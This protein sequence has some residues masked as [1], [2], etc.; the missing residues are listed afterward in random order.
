MGKNKIGFAHMQV[1][2]PCCGG[3]ATTE[4]RSRME[5]KATFGKMKVNLVEAS[6]RFYEMG[7]KLRLL[8]VH[9]RQ[10]QGDFVTEVDVERKG[11]KMS[12]V[13]RMGGREEKRE[14]PASQETFS[15][16]LFGFKRTVREGEVVRGH[17]FFEDLLQDFP[18]LTRVLSVGVERLGGVRLTLAD[19]QVEGL[20]MGLRMGGRVT[21][22][23]DL[24]T[25]TLG[26]V[27]LRLEG[28][29]A[30]RAPHSRSDLLDVSAPKV[31]K[32]VNR[33][34]AVTRLRVR[35]LPAEL[36]HN[37]ARQE[38][39]KLPDGSYRVLLRRLSGPRAPA[40][41]LPVKDPAFAKELAPTSVLQSDHPEIQRFARKAVGEEKDAF[42]AA[43]R[44]RDAVHA[45]MRPTWQRTLDALTALRAE[46]GMCYEF[47]H[48][49]AAAAR[50]VGIPSRL[51]YGL[52][53]TEIG[54]QARFVGHAWTELWVGEW[55][56]FDATEPTGP[57]RGPHFKLGD[58]ETVGGALSAMQ[59]LQIT[60]D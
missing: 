2:E 24:V 9:K 10:A 30:A 49:L 18:I 12:A 3:E 13:R 54:A 11:E 26:P 51:A 21:P 40:P 7:G 28:E 38:F 57:A 48:V 53:Y 36:V 31:P 14:I 42:R 34:N 19:M 27:T 52:I 43:M 44:L 58:S 22:D 37:D 33:D 47:A 25:G 4:L 23:G 35:G 56:P 59:G 17:Q 8:R 55:I 41:A 60:W 6:S 15:D 1:F 50:V 29:A 45:R 46:G 39:Q 5:M 32:L 20:P 16:A